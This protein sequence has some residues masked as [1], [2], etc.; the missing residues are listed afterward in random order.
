MTRLLIALFTGALLAGCQ[1]TSRDTGVRS[2]SQVDLN[3][4]IGTWYEQAHLP[5][6]FQRKCVRNTRAEYTLLPDQRIGVTNQ[7][8]TA[9][10]STMQ[11]EGKARVVP[12]T[13]NGQLKVSFF[14]PFE[15]DY[16]ILDLDPQYQWVAV[17]A[18]N[19]EY[20]WVLSREP[21]LPADQLQGILNR[22]RAQGF[23]LSTLIYTTQSPR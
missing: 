22:V 12:N 17:G 18:P 4:Y 16:W 20:F 3:R 10:G 1:T 11:A 6:F 9:D 21:Q 5:Q 13:G 8:E 15:G 14:W 7:C 23:D 2:V 19:R